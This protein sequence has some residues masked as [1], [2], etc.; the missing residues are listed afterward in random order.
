MEIGLLEDILY[1]KHRKL[2]ED[3]ELLQKKY[4]FAIGCI[5]YSDEV[6]AVLLKH[7]C[8][9]CEDNYSFPYLYD[10]MKDIRDDI[11]HNCIKDAWE[12]YLKLE[13][14]ICEEYITEYERTNDRRLKYLRLYWKLAQQS[15][16]YRGEKIKD[17]DREYWAEL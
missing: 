2:A 17:R 9:C 6:L 4:K 15:C 8:M 5:T 3:Y 10:F 13:K 7:Y 11:Q 1:P 14:N 12:E 16:E